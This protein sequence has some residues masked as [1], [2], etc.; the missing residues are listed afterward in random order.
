MA[1]KAWRPGPPKSVENFSPKDAMQLSPS[2]P[3]PDA[4]RKVV[5]H[6]VSI[7]AKQTTGNIICPPLASSSTTGVIFFF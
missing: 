5:G 2:K 6:M 7:E 3:I 1:N 4:V